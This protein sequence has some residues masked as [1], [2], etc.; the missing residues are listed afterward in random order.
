MLTRLPGGGPNS[1][2]ALAEA[3]MWA[4]ASAESWGVHLFELCITTR[5]WFG[6]GM[7]WSPG[8]NTIFN[9]SM[10]RIAEAPHGQ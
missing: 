4:S 2:S 10:T 9:D 3:F 7:E 6:G 8:Q 5:L 1:H